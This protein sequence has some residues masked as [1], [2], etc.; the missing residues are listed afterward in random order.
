MKC[1][2]RHM[3]TDVNMGHCRTPEH[4]YREISSEPHVPEEIISVVRTTYI[5]HELNPQRSKWVLYKMK[6]KFAWFVGR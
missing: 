3:N 6:R 1:T 4:L 2:S 5:I